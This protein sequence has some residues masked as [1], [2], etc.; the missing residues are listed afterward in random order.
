M[1]NTNKYTEL[2]KLGYK[3]FSYGNGWKEEPQEVHIHKSSDH[4]TFHEHDGRG[5]HLYWCE[6]CKIMW[7][8]DSS[9]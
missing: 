4:K 3:N 6:T 8:M 9:G 7:S 1:S 5:D 2:R